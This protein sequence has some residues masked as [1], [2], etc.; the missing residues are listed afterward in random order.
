M[1]VRWSDTSDGDDFSE[2]ARL[3]PGEGA[4]GLGDP[5]P[6]SVSSEISAC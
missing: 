5:Q 6:V 3:A 1:T 4:G 2:V